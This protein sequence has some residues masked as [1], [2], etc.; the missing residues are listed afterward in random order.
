MQV[1]KRSWS[2][3]TQYISL[4]YLEALWYVCSAGNDLQKQGKNITFSLKPSL[5]L[6]VKSNFS[7]LLVIPLLLPIS[8]RFLK[9]SYILPLSFE[10]LVGKT[11]LLNHHV[12]LA[13]YIYVLCMWETWYMSAE[14]M[15]EWMSD[16]HM[17]SCSLKCASQNSGSTHELLCL[18]I[19]SFPKTDYCK[20]YN[21]EKILIEP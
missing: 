18:P 20:N 16:H 6:Q 21:L 19:S 12:S 7:L 4:Y 13:S 8:N 14:W 15:N 1:L 9:L 10:L 2:K 5:I 17:I 11:L 3:H